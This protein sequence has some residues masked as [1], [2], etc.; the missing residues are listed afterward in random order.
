M[1][2]VLGFPVIPGI[3]AVVTYQWCTGNG[4][5]SVA[6]ACTDCTFGDGVEWC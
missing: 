5:L 3:A 2:E 6:S 1:S 4:A